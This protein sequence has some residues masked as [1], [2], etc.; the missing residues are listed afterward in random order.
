MKKIFCL[1]FV[2]FLWC[3]LSMAED[4]EKNVINKMLKSGW[5]FYSIQKSSDETAFFY[6]LNKNEQ[7]KLCIHYI[8]KEKTF[9][10][11]P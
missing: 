10:S 6:H 3:N 7:Y 4:S 2:I 9:C 11:T 5:K 1:V 8:L